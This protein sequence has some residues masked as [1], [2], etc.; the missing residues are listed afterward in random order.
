MH[1]GKT[2]SGDD[3]FGGK[4][5]VFRQGEGKQLSSHVNITT[6]AISHWINGHR[7]VP[8]L[9]L[10]NARVRVL[11]RI[12]V[13]G[14]DKDDRPCRSKMMNKIDHNNY[15]DLGD[16]NKPLVI[17]VLRGKSPRPGAK[18]G[19]PEQDD[20]FEEVPINAEFLGTMKAVAKEL[21]DKFT[22]GYLDGKRWQQFVV[23][24][25]ITGRVLPRILVMETVTER[26]RPVPVD[27][28]GHRGIVDYLELIN[29][30]NVTLTRTWER[31][32]RDTTREYM[33]HII[34]GFVGLVVLV[35]GWSI[36]SD[37][38]RAAAKKDVDKSD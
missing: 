28:K 24:Y 13:R 21:E 17:S 34:A 5:L 29:A 7:C 10:P 4:L 33:W 36:H 14:G 35:L 6:D 12:S 2:I 19:E 38:K 27:V 22:F 20:N 32:Y 9:A 15:N 26:H 11:L 25:G 37:Y 31:L 16:R 1:D 23:K 30:G 8:L 3:G 18:E